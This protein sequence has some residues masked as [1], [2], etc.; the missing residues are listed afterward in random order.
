[1]W[2]EAEGTVV[3]SKNGAWVKLELDP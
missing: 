1:M 3:V 2:D